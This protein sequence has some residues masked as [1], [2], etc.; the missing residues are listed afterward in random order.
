VHTL[1]TEVSVQLFGTRVRRAELSVGP[2]RGNDLPEL[3]RLIKESSRV[4]LNLDWWT[5]DDWVGNPAF[6]VAQSGKRIAGMAMGVRDAPPVAWLRALVV[7]DGLDTGALLDA[8][9]PPMFGALRTQG[10]P[11][12]TCLA[13]AEWLSGKLPERGFAPMAHVVTLRKDD[14]T[15]PDDR[16]TAGVLVRPAQPADLDAVTDIDHAAFEVEWWYSET[17]FFRVLSSPNRFIVAERNGEPV[18]Y[19]FGNVYGPQAHITR[20]AVHPA[21]QRQG[22]GARL[23]QDLVTH[24]A[25]SGA[26]TITLNTQTH[27]ESSLRLYRRFG[28]MPLGNAVTVWQR[29]L[30]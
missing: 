9:L 14:V 16:F 28:F 27:N 17:T 21:H 10:V 5:L 18:G 30:K 2:A 4:H 22:I 7:E 3:R 1:L 29:A 24:L 26:D 25:A 6:L 20:L 8:I 15:V 13:W 12:L 19:A 23:M 11:A